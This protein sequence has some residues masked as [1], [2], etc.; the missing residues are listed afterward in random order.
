MRCRF[1]RRPQIK[2]PLARNARKG[3]FEADDFR[4]LLAELP[5]YLRAVMQFAYSTGWRVRSEILPLTWDRVDFSAGIVRLRTNT[6]KNDAGRTFPFDVLPEL[7]AM[8]EA[9]HAAT[10]ALEH[11]AGQIIP[12]VF[13]HGGARIRDYYAAWRS[14][15]QRAAVMKKAGT[16]LE[17]IVRPQLLARIAHDFRRTAVRNLVRAGVSER[18]AMDLTG[19]KTRSVFDRYNVTSETELRAGIA[20][21]A[22]FHAH[23]TLTVQS[24]IRL[25]SE[26]K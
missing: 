14:A 17:V 24:G 26:G 23:G 18:V 6:T 21:L 15:C 7:A 8:L 3:F 9:Q 19:H 20:K 5:A 4:A 25:V 10:T 1:A 2:T 13:H 16:E 12:F 22:E 11:D